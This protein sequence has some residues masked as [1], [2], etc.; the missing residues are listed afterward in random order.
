LA[1]VETIENARGDAAEPPSRS[2]SFGTRAVAYAQHRPGYPVDAVRWAL[3]PVTDS[4]AANLRGVAVLDLAAGTGKLTEVLAAQGAEV[5]A[6]DPDPAMLA[7]LSRRLP[8]VQTLSGRAELIPVPDSTFD[9]VVAGQA[10]HWFDMDKA[11]GE[12]ARV[13][14]PGGVVAALWNLE[15]VRVSWVAGLA[16]VSVLPRDLSTWQENETVFAEHEGFG[17]PERSEFA[18]PQELTT[19]AFVARMATR[20]S[21]IVMAEDERAQVLARVRGYLRARPETASGSFVLPTVTGVDRA[22]RAEASR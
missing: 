9:A 3:A 14:R 12:I 11:M 22:T 13:L 2:T 5:V 17:A 18:H 8:S 6:V 10:F 1:D 16:E 4:G 19:D 20:S 15:D 21:L 7:E